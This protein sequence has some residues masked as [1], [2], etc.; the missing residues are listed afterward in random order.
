MANYD[1]KFVG[2]QEEIDIF[3]N[4]VVRFPQKNVLYIESGGGF[5]KTWLL[6]ELIQNH[7]KN[8]W[9]VWHTFP[10]GAQY[11]WE[12]VLIDFYRLENRTVAGLRRSIAGRIGWE[13]FPNFLRE[14][15]ANKTSAEDWFFKELLVAKRAIS[16][17]I[18]LFFDTFETVSDRHAGKWFLETFLRREETEGYFIVFAGRPCGITPP[19]NVLE[20]HLRPFDDDEVRAYFEEKF[21]TP[22]GETE[23]KIIQASERRPLTIDLLVH[24]VKVHQ[25]SLADILAN[26]PAKLESAL[27]ARFAQDG[28]PTGEA[29]R[30]LAYLTR[31]YSRDIFE[32]IGT[33]GSYEVIQDALKNYPFIKH[34]PGEHALTL[35]DEFQDMFNRCG[36]YDFQVWKQEL[37]KKVVQDWYPA[38]IKSNSPSFES[39]LLEAEHLYYLL[40]ENLEQGLQVYQQAW[41]EIQE[42]RQV[43][44]HEMLWGEVAARLD[45]DNDQETYN[46]YLSQANWLFEIG[47]RQLAAYWFEQ[48]ISERF[49]AVRTFDQ[50]AAASIRL[51]HCYMTTKKLQ[52]AQQLWESGLQKAKDLVERGETDA[53][54]SQALF[55]Y[56]LAHI[57]NR[58]EHIQNALEYYDQTIKLAR[59]IKDHEVYAEAA[60]VSAPILAMVGK[61]KEAEKRVENAR[62]FF[63]DHPEQQTPRIYAPALVYFGDT[64]RYLDNHGKAKSFYRKAQEILGKTPGADITWL[65]RALSGEA[66]SNLLIASDALQEEDNHQTAVDGLSKAWDLF[67][68]CLALMRLPEYEQAAVRIRYRVLDRMLHFYRILARWENVQSVDTAGKPIQDSLTSAI[69]LELPEEIPYLGKLTSSNIRFHE[70]DDSLARAQRMGELAFWMAEEQGMVNFALNALIQ[71]AN[72]AVQR[73]SYKELRK[74][75]RFML[76][77]RDLG[78]DMRE[79]LFDSFFALLKSHSLL[80]TD[81]PNAIE[82][83]AQHAREVAKFPGTGSYFLRI[84]MEL[85]QKALLAITA[86]EQRRYFPVLIKAWK[87]A[88]AP[89]SYFSSELQE[90]LDWQ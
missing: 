72:I 38:K 27:I 41:R 40:D 89:L 31:R 59:Q 69:S 4:I 7:C 39:Y 24:Y 12:D 77:L 3:R 85:I 50:W 56:N 45:K 19:E 26:P 5:G 71:S 58:S 2:R 65:V 35:H 67:Q 86:T 28:S 25:G 87:D 15:E 21:E 22:V 18:V 64:Y 81:L 36:G 17:Y 60:Y 20:Y 52:K 66:A 68:E 54:R 16:N 30:S 90:H 53:A 74:Y 49:Q 83:I 8:P 73:G 51:G 1:Q 79:G 34:R 62:K 37:F 33:E 44:R 70:L 29:I 75:H 43:Q 61:N 84:Y 80:E 10:A 55:T 76:A 88:P 23:E 13:H 48:I 42:G 32:H 47:E 11:T 14:D 78:D 9:R 6:Q 82:E 63:L 46:L 57:L